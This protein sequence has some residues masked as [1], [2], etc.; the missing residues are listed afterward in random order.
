MGPKSKVVPSPFTDSLV[1][2]LM[3]LELGGA[4]R[5]TQA[6]DPAAVPDIVSRIA[7][8]MD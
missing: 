7:A 1:R 5:T 8:T 6:A 2:M 3:S 4:L